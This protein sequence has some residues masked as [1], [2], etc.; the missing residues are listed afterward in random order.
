MSAYHRHELDAFPAWV[1]EARCWE[2]S[3]TGDLGVDAVRGSGLL[4]VLWVPC[5][6]VCKRACTCG[7]SIP[8]K[9]I[10]GHF[11]HVRFPPLEDPR[12]CVWGVA[13]REWQVA[14]LT[15]ASENPPD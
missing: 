15:V 12:Q 9:T 10:S 1:A 14:V 2:A 7:G 6:H 3:H 13:E 4:R 11:L 8:C 5:A